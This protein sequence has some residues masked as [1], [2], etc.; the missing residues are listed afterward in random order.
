MTNQDPKTGIHYGV[1]SQNNIV[2]SWAEYSEPVYGP[3]CCPYCGKEIKE[4]ENEEAA[5]VDNAA[6]D[7]YCKN[8]GREFSGEDATPEEPTGYM[9][10]TEKL[11][12]QSCLDNDVMIVLSEFFT[13]CR[14]CS[15]CVPNAGDLNSPAE[16]GE[17]IPAYCFSPEFYYDEEKP[18]F[19]IYSVQ[20]RQKVYTAEASAEV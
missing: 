15:P 18:G 4:D 5:A 3:I 1:I 20:T 12:A 10:D 6:E 2:Q 16:E 19:D 11:K 8:C 7:F 17:G 9:I 14:P 13:Y